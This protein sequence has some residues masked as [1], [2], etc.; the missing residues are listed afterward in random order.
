MSHPVAALAIVIAGVAVLAVCMVA[1]GPTGEF[2]GLA[3]TML[4]PLGTYLQVPG[5]HLQNFTLGPQGGLLVGTIHWDHS[6]IVFGVVP[7]GL[8]SC[9]QLMNYSG[10]PWTEQLNQSLTAGWHTIGPICGGFANGTVT[11][12]VEVL[13]P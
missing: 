11:Q 6:S 12:A 9:V 5:L 13:Y 10:P 8:H 7:T 2:S 4:Y 1:W 3:E